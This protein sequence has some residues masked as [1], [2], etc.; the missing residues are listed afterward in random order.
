MVPAAQL[1]T[2]Y[3]VCLYIA[4]LCAL[5]CNAS[6]ICRS[7]ASCQLTRAAAGKLP[8]PSPEHDVE[9][10][11]VI[12][13]AQ[14]LIQLQ[15]HFAAVHHLR[16]K[17]TATMALKQPNQTTNNQQLNKQPKGNQEMRND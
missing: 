2:Q 7:T 6:A 4:T 3:G 5:C 14:P 9:H 11:G 16:N 8:Q 10:R 12:I 17:D 15:V 13:Q 1:S